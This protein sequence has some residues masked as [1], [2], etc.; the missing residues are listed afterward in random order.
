MKKLLSALVLAG[1][2]L[3]LIIFAAGTVHAAS[4]RF[5]RVTESEGDVW[6]L[7]AGMDEWE[8]CGVNTPLGETDI[9]ETEDD[10]YAEIQLD[11]GAI[12]SLNQDTRVDFKRMT[13]NDEGGKTTVLG[14]PFGSAM[15]R[16]FSY[17]DPS[18]NLLIELPTGRVYVEEKASLR[19]NVKGNGASHVLVYE[20]RAI[21]EG[22]DGDVVI[23]KGKRGYV[24][25]DGYLGPV[26]RLP[27]GRDYFYSWCLDNYNKYE[28]GESRRYLDD[29][30]YY[31][32][33]YDLD[34]H[35]T[36]VYVADHG[37]CW[38]PSVK[39]GWYPYHSGYWVWSVHWGWTWVSYEPWGWIPYH[40][41]TWVHSW[42]WGWV[43][44]PGHTWGP[45][46]VV[47]GYYDGCVGWAPLGPWGHP[48]YYGYY[49]GYDWPWT[50]V[51]RD[52]FY[53]PYWKYK[54]RGN[55]KYRHY[56]W[57]R[58]RYRFRDGKGHRPDEYRMA[59]PEEPELAS[60]WVTK[61]V[62]DKAL[63]NA[64]K[65]TL[66]LA[67]REAPREKT[68]PAN[69]TN[70]KLPSKPKTVKTEI[71]KDDVQ[72]SNREKTPA[73]R[74]EIL[75]LPPKPKKVEAERESG[76]GHI[77]AEEKNP[78]AESE[79]QVMPSKPR[80]VEKTPEKRTEDRDRDRREV[81]P[82]SE[83]ETYEWGESTEEV[84]RPR[85]NR[86]EEKLTSPAETNEKRE[87]HQSE[88]TKKTSQSMTGQSKKEGR[89]GSAASTPSKMGKS[90]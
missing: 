45:A 3:F 56:E 63:S 34:R 79:A 41:G 21:L 76:K 15:I 13:F 89:S 8:P 20:G 23:K 37:Y 70:K 50:Y 83:P 59:G 53:H 27:E 35:G 9:V 54:Y 16:V 80:S 18:D 4:M 68:S 55:R 69:I 24:D 6:V 44:V 31:G 82:R 43:W 65:K 72:R 30:S 87:K 86:N 81:A 25:S 2:T 33:V 40:Y 46:W 17:R 73:A 67:L 90:R 29:D 12:I 49:Y 11:N 7:R 48:Y 62:G 32:G 57:G 77:S 1:L 64:D 88:E 19:I 10:S 47:W 58:K 42:R 84:E 78:V 74:S 22:K 71:G 52:S 14:F 60:K 38:R 51:Y 5:A 26:K 75:R 66:P 85:A 36:W 39:V 61:P 28:G